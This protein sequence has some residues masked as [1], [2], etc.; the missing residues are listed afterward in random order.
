MPTAKMQNKTTNRAKIPNKRCIKARLQ[1]LNLLKR[2]HEPPVLLYFSGVPGW[3]AWFPLQIFRVNNKIHFSLANANNSA[4]FKRKMVWKWRFLLIHKQQTN[5]LVN[6]AANDSAGVSGEDRKIPPALGT[7]Q[8]A[9]FGGFRPL[10]SLGKKQWGLAARSGSE[11]TWSPQLRNLA[12]RNCV[13]IFLQN[14]YAGEC[15][16]RSVTRLISP[17]YEKHYKLMEVLYIFPMIFKVKPIFN[18]I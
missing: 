10:S 18:P 5:K 15:R 3:L 17:I 16:P 14:K 2:H 9:G 7:N 11:F 6:E 12:V 13:P 8:V 1:Y 4:S